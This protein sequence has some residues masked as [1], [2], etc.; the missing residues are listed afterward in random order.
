LVTSALVRAPEL[1]NAEIQVQFSRQRIEVNSPSMKLTSEKRFEILRQFATMLR[2]FFFEISL[3]IGYIW[4]QSWSKNAKF[5]GKIFFC[6]TYV[7]FVEK[8]ILRI[9]AGSVGILVTWFSQYSGL[10]PERSQVPKCFTPVKHQ[11]T[12]KSRAALYI[13]LVTKKV[14]LLCYYSQSFQVFFQIN[15]SIKEY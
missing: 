11:R 12:K 1:Q 14:L 15:L 3:Q 5:D 6:Q 4:L 9:F 13:V 7:G 2:M 8:K 10:R